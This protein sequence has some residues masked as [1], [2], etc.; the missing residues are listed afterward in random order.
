ME[1]IA[2]KTNLDHNE[3]RELEETKRNKLL[4]RTVRGMNNSA[5]HNVTLLQFDF[6]KKKADAGESFIVVG[7][8]AEFVLKG[9]PAVISF[10]VLGDHDVK[11]QRIM[12]LY[13]LSDIEARAMMYDNDRRRKQYHNSYCPSKWGD[14]RYYDLS[15]NSSKLGIDGSVKIMCEYINARIVEM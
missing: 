5:T 9:H 4:S 2:K 7:R 14:S 10:F 6:L 13:H 11:K 3:L 15:I 8:C 1:E 12:E